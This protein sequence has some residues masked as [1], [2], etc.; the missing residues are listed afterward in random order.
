MTPEAIEELIA[1]RVAE[2]LANYE[3]TRA[4]NAL[5]AESQ[6]QNGNDG[7]NGNGG[8]GN[9]NHGDGGNNRN[10]NPNENGRGAMSVA[11]V[12]TYQDFVK[13]RPLNFKGT[14]G[15]VGLTRWS[16]KIEIVFHISNC[17]E[18]YQV[19]MVP[20]EEDRIESLMNQMLKGYAIRSA[21]NKRKFESNQ[22]DNRAQQ[23]KFK[24]QN[25]RGSNVARAYTAGGHFKKDCPK[26]KNQNHGNKP[27]IPEARGKAY[28][29]GGGDAN[30]VSNVAT[31]TFLLNN[32]YASVLFDS[33]ADRSFVSTTFSTLLDIILDTLDVSHLFNID[34]MPVK[35]GSFNVIIG[36][37]WLANNYA[38]IVC[39]EKIVRIPFGDE[40]L[41]VQGDRNDKGKKLTLNIISCTET[42]K[43]MEKGCQVF[44][45]QVTKKEMEV[46]SQEK[47]L[48]DVSIVR[49]FPKVF[50]K[51][52]P[53][54]PPA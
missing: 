41:I 12:C 43:Y 45:T 14:E 35:L 17:P 40:I 53:G 30:P 28:A 18:V 29:I 49:K 11:H 47:R 15:V 6:I 42:Q 4:A 52:L 37:D 39:D 25:V 26:L 2:A 19:K 51:D 48:E 36:M 9:G 27:V 16:E 31:G 23:P 46:K 38:V 21:E 7:N 13:C 32:H 5:E 22:K 33:G 44:L 8:N 34:L 10:G 50:P 1:Q 3:V 24:K 20:E 54:L